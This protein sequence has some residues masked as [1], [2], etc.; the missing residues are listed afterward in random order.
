MP[1][2]CKVVVN[3]LLCFMQQK[4]NTLD[5]LS[6]IELCDKTFDDKTVE[7]A[8][9]IIISSVNAAATSRKGDGRKKRNLQD[10]LKLL[11]ET[12]PDTL[13]VFAA[14]KLSLLP[15]VTFDYIDV[16]TLLQS[17]TTLKFEI[18][19]LK[20]DRSLDKLAL[21]EEISVL[22]EDVCLLK[23][24][25][26]LSGSVELPKENTASETI[27]LVPAASVSLTASAPKGNLTTCDKSPSQKTTIKT[28]EPSTGKKINLVVG[29]NTST[30]GLTVA[31]PCKYICVSRL[32]NTCTSEQV[33]QHIESFGVTDCQVLKVA[34][35]SGEFNTFKVRIP[36][37]CCDLIFQPS[38]W[39]KGVYVKPWITI[40]RK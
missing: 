10:I 4:Y 31:E 15:P 18:N 38:N 40:N 1:C 9:D 24:Q 3:E 21:L 8:K 7:D 13:P 22:K 36:A 12:D 23:S 19:K 26:I 17:I 11:R 6:L 30:S 35:R 39:P 20:Q 37:K 16:S 32:S 33:S 27:S 29:S 5:E 2:E 14:V 25:T 34:T 28:L